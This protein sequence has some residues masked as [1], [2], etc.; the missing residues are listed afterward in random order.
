MAQRDENELY[1]T[2]F[3]G[4]AGWKVELYLPLFNS[5]AENEKL[6]LYFYRCSMAQRDEK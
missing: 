6:E 3:N 5:T 1:L 2:L 4:T